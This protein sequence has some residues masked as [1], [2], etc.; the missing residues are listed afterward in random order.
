MKCTC[1][2][3]PHG[4]RHAADCPAAKRDKRAPRKRTPEKHTKDNAR[5]VVVRTD[6]AALRRE[7]PRLAKASVV[8][9]DE[10]ATSIAAILARDGGGPHVY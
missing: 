5:R 4:A 9:Q 10:V 7:L 8:A 1:P 2:E 6:H 3:R